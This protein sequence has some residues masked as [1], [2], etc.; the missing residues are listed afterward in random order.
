M[1]GNTSNLGSRAEQEALKIIPT[2]CRRDP[3]EMGT[4]LSPQVRI[5]EMQLT[6]YPVPRITQLMIFRFYLGRKCGKMRGR[7]TNRRS[8]YIWSSRAVRRE[9]GWE[10]PASV[11]SVA[12]CWWIKESSDPLL[13][14]MM[15]G[16]ERFSA[17]SHPVDWTVCV[18]RIKDPGK[19]HSQTTVGMATS[20][21]GRV[22]HSQIAA[23]REQQHTFADRAV[24]DSTSVQAVHQDVS[25]AWCRVRIKV[26][27]RK[28]FP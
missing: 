28:P 3:H 23:A 14:A 12:R 22:V 4:Q 20:N 9:F 24:E 6:E 5:W 10:I 26:C 25:V 18:S 11:N 15:P 1:S 7:K 16:D 13:S 8:G 27:M 2:P 19:I 17:L 21:A